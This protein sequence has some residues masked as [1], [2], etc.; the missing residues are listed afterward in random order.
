MDFLLLLSDKTRIVIEIDGKQHYSEGDRSSPRLYSEMVKEDRALRLKGYEVYRF[1][2]FEL[3]S[4][5]AEEI[6]KEFFSN[7]FKKHCL[8]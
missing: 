3:S 2:G 7:L 1:G 6:V 5:Q 8:L 4:D